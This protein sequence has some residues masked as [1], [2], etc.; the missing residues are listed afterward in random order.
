MT[1]FISKSVIG[2][3]QTALVYGEQVEIAFGPVF[4]RATDLWKWQG[5]NLPHAKA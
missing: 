5:K 1:K 4:N 3:W 2:G